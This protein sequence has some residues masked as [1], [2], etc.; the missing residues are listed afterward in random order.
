L[1]EFL[2]FSQSLSQKA[3]FFIHQAKHGVKKKSQ[4]IQTE[5]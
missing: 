4:Q 2:A 1:K 3:I 5:Q